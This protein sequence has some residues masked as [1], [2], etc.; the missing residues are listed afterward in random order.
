M[1][2]G[3]DYSWDRP[4]PVQLVA[5][6]FSFAIRYVSLDWRIIGGRTKVLTRGEA[7]TLDAA[8]L[9]VVVVWE[10][11]A[12]DRDPLSGAAQG[13]ADALEA[14]RQALACGA[15]AGVPIYFAADWDANAAD[16]DRMGPYFQAAALAL[17]GV[18]RVGVY[19]S[20]RTVS[21]LLSRGL[22]GFGWQTYAWSGGQW[23]ARAQLRQVANSQQIAGG[24]VDVNEALTDQFGQWRTGGAGMTYAPVDLLSVQRYLQAKTGLP[25]VSLGIVGDPAH[26]TSG[27]HI[28]GRTTPPTDYSRRESPRDNPVGLTDAASALDV[29]GGWA[30]WREFTLW[31]VSRCRAGD[32]RARDIREV[33][34]TPDGRTVAR[35]DR[36]GVRSDGDVS[37]LTH[38]HVSFYRDSEGRRHLPDN[39]MGL[40]TEFF[41]GIKGDDDMSDAQ[42]QQILSAVGGWYERL[43]VGRTSSDPANFKMPNLVDLT[44]QVDVLSATVAALAGKPAAALTDAQLNLLV[45]GVTKAVV[46]RPDNPLGDKDIPAIRDAL[47]EELSSVIAAVVKASTPAG[48]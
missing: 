36:L 5:A 3:V 37:H 29:G 45:E 1:R 41:D 4:D 12:A 28:G 43:M 11:R 15:P 35:W 23:D 33:I 21:T 16:V 42:V 46:T 17:G 6:G 25:W 14:Q 47:R 18:H 31:L 10:G 44:K 22:V 20:F 30:R 26:G 32:T 2:R 13:T 19:G 8:G 38:T 27:Y 24:A 34:Y 7:E 48:Q 9:D 40:A 39:F